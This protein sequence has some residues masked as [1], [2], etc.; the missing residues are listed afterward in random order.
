MLADLLVMVE[1]AAWVSARPPLVMNLSSDRCGRGV[2]MGAPD[3][4]AADPHAE[5]RAQVRS[6]CEDF[7]H[8]Y[9]RDLD[10]ER[11]YPEAFVEA[12]TASGLLGALIPREH[13]GLGLPLAAASVILEEVNRSGGNAGP[14]HAQMYIM[15]TVL[16]HGSEAQKQAYLPQ[17]AEGELRLQAFG[18]TEPQAG[19]DTTRIRTR[20]V[21]DGDRYLVNGEKVYISRVQHSDLSSCWCGPRR[22]SRC[23]RAA[24]ACP[25]SLSTC[26]TRSATAWRSS[27]SGP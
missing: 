21:R 20:A 19:T 6:V 14:A 11:A 13:G 18:V 5:L 23:A 26:A 17:I 2:A 16:R 10:R 9:W 4:V 27:R 1:G 8:R 24:T 25:C 12:M 22:W 7:P 3:A 15:G